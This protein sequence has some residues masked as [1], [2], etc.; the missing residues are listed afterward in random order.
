[1]HIWGNDK[2]EV[3]I[4]AGGHYYLP[5]ILP[6]RSSGLFGA[7]HGQHNRVDLETTA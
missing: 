7:G 4:Q 3:R 6:A 1:M 5:G 2:V